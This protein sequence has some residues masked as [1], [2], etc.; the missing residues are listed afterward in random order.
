MN[1]MTQ[2]EREQAIFII[3]GYHV[4]LRVETP[5][6]TFIRAKEHAVAQLK[7]QLNIVES[8]TFEQFEYQ[9]TP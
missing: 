3:E 8:I 2:N 7:R 4:K 5:L 9:H 1:E 6:T